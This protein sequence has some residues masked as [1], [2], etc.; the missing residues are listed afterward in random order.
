VVERANGP[1]AI[2]EAGDA[3]PRPAN[4]LRGGGHQGPGGLS[5]QGE[6]QLTGGHPGS[7][8]SAG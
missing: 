2:V 6:G 7:I 3:G 5:L 8:L 1:Y 4:D